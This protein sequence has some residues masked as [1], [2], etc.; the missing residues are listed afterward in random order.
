[1][2]K[3]LII[4]SLLLLASC[5]GGNPSGKEA[6]ISPDASEEQSVNAINNEQ[7][8]DSISDE[9]S[10]SFS[11]EEGINVVTPAVSPSSVNDTVLNGSPEVL[12]ENQEVNTPDR[13]VLQRKMVKEY[14]TNK[15]AFDVLNNNFMALVPI[16]KNSTFLSQGLPKNAVIEDE[17]LEQNNAQD[18]QSIEATAQ[19]A[20]F[21]NTKLAVLSK[22]D[23]FNPQ[24]DVL[25]EPIIIS[26]VDL[27]DN[28]TTY[29]ATN[30]PRFI[31]QGTS[32]FF[33]KNKLA[34]ADLKSF[35]IYINSSLVIIK[36]FYD[37]GSRQYIYDIA[38]LAG[39]T[40]TLS[41]PWYRTIEEAVKLEVTLN[42][43]KISDLN[44]YNNILSAT[45]KAAL[46]T[47]RQA[48]ASASQIST[49]E[50]SG[51]Q[52]N[53]TP[54][55]LEN[56]GEGI[57]TTAQEPSR[58]AVKGSPNNLDPLISNA[59]LPAL[60]N[61]SLEELVAKQKKLIAF[62]IINVVGYWEDLH[63][64]EVF[65]IRELPGNQLNSKSKNYAAYIKLENEITNLKINRTLSW[66]NEDLKFSFN[67][68]SGKGIYLNLEKMLSNTQVRAYP[69]KGMMMIFL[70]NKE[71]RYLIPIISEIDQQTYN[72]LYA[73]IKNQYMYQ[74][75]SSL[76]KL[77][78]Y[79]TTLKDTKSNKYFFLGFSIP[80]ILGAL[81]LLL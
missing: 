48:N 76:Y 55:Q 35:A 52:D 57:T 21:N 75:N 26:S 59:E 29:A 10:G 79:Q 17:I 45:D 39:D 8:V 24:M 49:E 4:I 63:N 81:L 42:N 31:L 28:L 30:F 58:D 23:Q 73:D 56:K 47:A 41:S 62:R 11:S 19:T 50:S 74:I 12:S 20:E 16:R 64:K 60:S 7:T 32:K 25:N 80:I 61:N 33:Y 40:E 6:V 2:Q 5:F 70:P 36:V 9:G 3:I 14:F 13:S 15:R 65:E 18:E 54:E 22:A 34:I 51:G 69:A 1:M 37:Q 71:V 44:S 66:I 78:K 46:K 67:S 53:L 38:Y 72:D 27:Y 68:L 43:R 77:E